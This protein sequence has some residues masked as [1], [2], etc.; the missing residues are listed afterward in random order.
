MKLNKKIGKVEWKQCDFTM[1]LTDV[2][3]AG[4]IY[5]ISGIAAGM[6]VGTRIAESVQARNWSLRFQFTDGGATAV[7]YPAIRIILFRDNFNQGALPAL[8]EVVDTLTMTS[9]RN[10]ENSKRFKVY[11]DKIINLGRST[12]PALSYSQYRKVNI[13][14]NHIMK[15]DGATAAVTDTRE[16]SLNILVFSNCPAGTAPEFSYASRIRFTDS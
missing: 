7:N 4:A 15:F 3:S 13:K 8:T 16:G 14:L 2:D 5:Q 6:V 9:L 11:Y 1:G 10:L 12:N